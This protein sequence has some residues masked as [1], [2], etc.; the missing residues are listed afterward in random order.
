MFKVPFPFHQ[1]HYL[2]ITVKF[3]IL[4][5][6]KPTLVIPISP[7]LVV[8]YGILPGCAESPFMEAMLITLPQPG[9]LVRINHANKSM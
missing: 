5:I 9:T 1:I 8:Q 4:D 2:P 3:A 7:A 6:R